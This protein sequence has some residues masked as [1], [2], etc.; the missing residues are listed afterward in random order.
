MIARVFIA[1]AV[2][3]TTA[4]ASA[5]PVIAVLEYRANAK[6]ALGLGQ[7]FSQLLSRSVAADI[8]ELDEAR[9]R[10][11]TKLDADVARCGNQLHCLAAIGNTLGASEVLLI[12][13]SQ[14]GD[15]V[16]SLQR[17]DTARGELSGRLAESLSS[18][19]EPSDAELMGWLK[20]LF[21]PDY[22]LRYGEITIAANVDDAKVTLNGIDRGRTPLE[23]GLKMRA[24]ATYRL[25][26]EREGYVP[27]EA[28]IDLV[29]EG[30]MEVRATLQR[31]Q[32]ETP[33]Y[34]RWYLWASVGAVAVI[35]GAGVAIYFGTRTDKDPRGQ[36][37]LPSQ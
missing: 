23:R 37:I 8:V 9:R 5:R 28:R 17:I 7:R 35:A 11:G 32:K 36:L 25:R 29:P 33:V 14:L 34:K 1:L 30:K 13:V 6:G 19:D 26:V 16:V 27:F 31:L 20:R 4:T 10:L 12:G 15:V 21:P 22:F 3:L 18:A 24:P 2:L